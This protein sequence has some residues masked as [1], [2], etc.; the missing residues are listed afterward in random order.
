LFDNIAP[1]FEGDSSSEDEQSV[2]ERPILEEQPSM[3]ENVD[4]ATPSARP[5]F[6][7]STPIRPDPSNASDDD[8]AQ[9]QDPTVLAQQPLRRSR[10][11]RKKRRIFDP[12]EESHAVHLSDFA[13]LVTL[14][15]DKDVTPELVMQHVYQAAAK[16]KSNGIEDADPSAFLP[17]PKSLKKIANMEPPIR[18]A[19]LD[20]F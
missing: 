19:W 11:S 2:E 13:N 8:D 15:F 6:S 20:A 9:Y 17:E 3:E 5:S 16:F 7:P 4:N 18:K 12:S 10:R 1:Q 14:A